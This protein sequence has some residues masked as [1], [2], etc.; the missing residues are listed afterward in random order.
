MYSHQEGIAWVQSI[1]HEYAAEYDCEDQ[2][3]SY[4]VNDKI[5]VIAEYRLENFHVGDTPIALKIGVRY[6]KS[7]SF[8]FTPLSVRMA[9]HISANRKTNPSRIGSA[10][11]EAASVSTSTSSPLR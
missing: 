2:R 9:H 1:E 7:V 6:L 8:K 11:T 5:K 3:G 4:Y 10:E